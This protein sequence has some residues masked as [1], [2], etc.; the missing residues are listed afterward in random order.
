MMLGSRRVQSRSKIDVIDRFFSWGETTLCPHDAMKDSFPLEEDNLDYVFNSVESFA[1]RED[2]VA[3][4]D[5]YLT[6]GQARTIQRDNSLIEVCSSISAKLNKN[7]PRNNNTSQQ[8]QIKPIGESGDILD[9]CF[10]NLESYACG[11]E[12]TTEVVKNT[13]KPRRFTSRVTDVKCLSSSG[14]EADNEVLLF[15]RPNQCRDD[16]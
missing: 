10:D 5:Q 7:L 6:T 12:A 16:A 8:R 14:S 15:Y 1:C 11:E 4:D 13:K 2:I 3:E 9:Y